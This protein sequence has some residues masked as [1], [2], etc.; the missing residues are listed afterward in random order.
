MATCFCFISRISRVSCVF[1]GFNGSRP[2]SRWPS[3]GARNAGRAGGLELRPAAAGALGPRGGGEAGLR[4]AQELLG[5]QL[6]PAARLALVRRGRFGAHV[7]FFWVQRVPL[8]QEPEVFFAGFLV[9][10]EVLG[11]NHRFCVCT[12]HVESFLE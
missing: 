12:L 9:I 3:R 2:T 7:R 10:L 6:P 4:L 11:N 5:A 8:L 1:V